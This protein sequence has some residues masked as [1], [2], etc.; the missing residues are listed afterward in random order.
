MNFYILHKKDK[1][2]I[3]QFKNKNNNKIMFQIY[4]I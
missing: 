1:I 3:T 2:K 4:W